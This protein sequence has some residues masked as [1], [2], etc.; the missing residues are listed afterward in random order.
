MNAD[1]RLVQIATALKVAGVSFLIMGGHA[2]RYFGVSRDTFDFDFHLSLAA[3]HDLTE[4]LQ[5]TELFGGRLPAELP[6]WRG[7]DFRR[8]RLGFLPNGKEEWL[9]FWFRNHLLPAYAELYARREEGEVAGERLPFLSLPD[10]IH[11]KETERESDWLDV[12]LLEEI[13]D[14]RNLARAANATEKIL[15]LANL[16][17]R[18][19]YR[20]AETQ[21]LFG[22]PSMLAAALSRA[23]N[24]ISKAFLFPF[25]PQSPAEEAAGIPTFMVDPLLQ[26]PPGSSRHMALV[27]A[28]RRVYRQRAVAADR[29]DKERARHGE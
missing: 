4:R 24:P 16:R 25:V 2:A 22:D 26:V 14:G 12:A 9:E 20:L 17:S 23:Q 7:E 19:G 18:R 11:S 8:F 1:A 28:I 6:S 10:L 15:A 13:L 21:G 3:R 29:A 27:E 5:Q